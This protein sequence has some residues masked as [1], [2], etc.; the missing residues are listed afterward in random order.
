MWNILIVILIAFVI[1]VLNP[2]S[3]NTKL[4]NPAQNSIQKQEAIDKTEI[5]QIVNQVEEQVDFAHE[6]QAQQVSDAQHR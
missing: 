2:F 4:Y 5:N 3:S 6:I 1:F